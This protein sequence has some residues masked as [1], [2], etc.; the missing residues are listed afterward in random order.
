MGRFA[1]AERSAAKPRAALEAHS[2]LSAEQARRMIG[3]G[4]CRSSSS[5]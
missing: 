4:R 3:S 1:R 5:I 2:F